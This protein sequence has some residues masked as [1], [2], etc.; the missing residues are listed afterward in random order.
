MHAYKLDCLS[1][2]SMLRGLGEDKNARGTGKQMLENLELPDN[3]RPLY[4][5]LADAIGERIASGEL[6][7][8]DRLPPHREI[9]RAARHQCHDR[10]PRLLG[11]ATAR[12]GRG[13]PR[14]RNTVA[15][16]EAEEGGFKSAP[17]RRGRPDRSVG[18]PAGDIGLS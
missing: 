14:P 16:R 2:G 12:A 8:G 1:F 15:A 4:Q 13:A 7:E 17:E 9:A 10:H 11:L 5:R 18:Q 6:A 3:D